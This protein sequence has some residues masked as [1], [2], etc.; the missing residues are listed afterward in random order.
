MP[1]DR[2]LRPEFV[3]CLPVG[4]EE[5]LAAEGLTE[6]VE[7]VDPPEWVGLLKQQPMGTWR[8]LI[9]SVQGDLLGVT[10]VSMEEM[11]GGRFTFEF[12]AL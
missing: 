2:V 4:M 5:A 7:G 3:R 12:L 9:R 1:L 10:A 11:E 6:E 8:V